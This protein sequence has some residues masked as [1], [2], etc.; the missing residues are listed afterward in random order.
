MGG[1]FGSLFPGLRKPLHSWK[2]SSVHSATL[3]VPDPSIQHQQAK[4]ANPGKHLFSCVKHLFTNSGI[5][6]ML[7]CR[8]LITIQLKKKN[9]TKTWPQNLWVK[10]TPFSNLKGKLNSWERNLAKH[11][12][13][14]KK[15]MCYLWKTQNYRQKIK[16]WMYVIQ[17]S[18]YWQQKISSLSMVR[19][20][21]PQTT[22]S[23]GVKAKHFWDQYHRKRLL[24]AV[25]V[26]G[27]TMSKVA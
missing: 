17:F 24:Q 13:Y 16:F 25:L 10:I 26:W 2:N 18:Y 14:C 7:Y 19:D 15:T 6:S 23:T 3:T 12:K 9:H 8:Y 11:T 20:T 22:D 5:I 27:I 21:L 1:S 4:E